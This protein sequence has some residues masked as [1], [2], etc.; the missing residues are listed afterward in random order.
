LAVDFIVI[1]FD[2]LFERQHR[3][4]ARSRNRVDD[5]HAIDALSTSEQ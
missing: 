3:N 2:Y 5:E 1:T 4:Q